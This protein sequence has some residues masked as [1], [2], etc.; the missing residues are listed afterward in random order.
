M[1]NFGKPRASFQ[2]DN[3]GSYKAILFTSLA[4]GLIIW[5]DYKAFITSLLSISN[6]KYPFNDL[7]TLSKT[8]YV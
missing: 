7:D 8:D 6:V 5:L 3:I 2:I 4:A 1:A